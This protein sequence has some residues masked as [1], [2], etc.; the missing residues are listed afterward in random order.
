MVRRLEPKLL[1]PAGVQWSTFKLVCTFDWAQ[2]DIRTCSGSLSGRTCESS[3]AWSSF[4]QDCNFNRSLRSRKLSTM[5]VDSGRRSETDCW[6]AEATI[7]TATCSAH[8]RMQVYQLSHGVMV[9]MGESSSQTDS[10]SGGLHAY[11]AEEAHQTE[12]TAVAG[13]RQSALR[14]ANSR[15]LL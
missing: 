13:A 3:C 7:S 8:T 6:L 1:L 14:S 11:C 12:S 4:M 9:R 15:A 10:H 2:S 5:C